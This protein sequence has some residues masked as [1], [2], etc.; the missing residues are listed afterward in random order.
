MKK[1]AAEKGIYTIK[2]NIHAIA[3]DLSFRYGLK[4]VPVKIIG[5]RWEALSSIQSPEK[6]L[7]LPVKITISSEYALVI[8]SSFIPEEF[9]IEIEQ[10]K[11]GL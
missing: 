4:I 11:T 1:Y 5:K 3:E 7:C 6:D 10:Y 9:Y 2:M 8:Y